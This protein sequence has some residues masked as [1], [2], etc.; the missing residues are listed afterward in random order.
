[1]DAPFITLDEIKRGGRPLTVL[2]RVERHALGIDL[3]V[4]TELKA[5]DLFLR[6]TLPDLKAVE[7]TGKDG[8]AIEV[9]GKIELVPLIAK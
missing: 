7:H 6:K 3:M 1:M 4:A 5:A 9:I 8:G 2:E